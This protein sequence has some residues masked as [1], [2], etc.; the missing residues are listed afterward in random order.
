MAFD[1]IEATSQ[2]QLHTLLSMTETPKDFPQLAVETWTAILTEHG[3][4]YFDLKRC[5]R[6]SRELKEIVE[7]RPRP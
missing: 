4:T 7:V 1:R 2:Q 5:G 3:L 6:V